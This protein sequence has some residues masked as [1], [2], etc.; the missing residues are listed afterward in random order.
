[1]KKWKNP[2]SAPLWFLCIY[3]QCWAYR[4]FF[5]AGCQCRYVQCWAYRQFFNAGCQCRFFQRY[6]VFITVYMLCICLCVFV[7]LGKDLLKALWK[8]LMCSV[9]RGFLKAFLRIFKVSFFNYCVCVC[10]HMCIVFNYCIFFRDTTL[11][12]LCRTFRSRLWGSLPGSLRAFLEGPPTS[13][14][15]LR[16][17]RAWQLGSSWATRTTSAFWLLT[18]S[19]LWRT[20]WSTS[21][22]RWRLFFVFFF[23]WRGCFFFAW[24]GEGEGFFFCI[25][26]IPRHPWGWQHGFVLFKEVSPGGLFL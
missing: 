12:W 13:W 24:R 18:G 23:G 4:Q 16:T 17:R 2:G 9:F 6:S 19:S 22:R 26:V 1:M 20:V 8:F 25:V 3:V 11:G 5:N 7:K 15:T 10:A 21:I 14:S